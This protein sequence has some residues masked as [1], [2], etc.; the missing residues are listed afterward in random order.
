MVR[1]HHKISPWKRRRSK[2]ASL[3][4]QPSPTE[5]QNGDIHNFINTSHLSFVSWKPALLHFLVELQHD[6]AYL[7]QFPALNQTSHFLQKPASHLQKQN[8]SKPTTNTD[9]QT[10]TPG[11]LGESPNWL[12][13]S[14]P[15]RVLKNKTFFFPLWVEE[16][17]K[18]NS[19]QPPSLSVG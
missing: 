19:R 13:F 18:R 4:L 17:Y 3:L 7:T 15:R 16:E 6:T 14:H 9:T 10:H 8:Q 11:A 12:V 5:L 2:Q 1:N